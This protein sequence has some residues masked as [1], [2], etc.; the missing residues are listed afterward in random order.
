MHL[1]A[2]FSLLYVNELI[3]YVNTP[4]PL[5]NKMQSIEK[6]KCLIIDDDPLIT[7]LIVH[8]CDKLDEIEYCLACNNAVDGLKLISSQEF[9]VLFLDYNMPE[10]N[11]KAILE[12][13]K[14]NSKV[15]MITSYADFAVDSYNYPQL[16]DYL[17]KPIKFD[18]FVQAINKLKTRQE[19]QASA[20][21]TGSYFIKDGSKWV[22][23]SLADIIYI[24]SDSNYVV[25]TTKKKQVLEL[26]KLKTLEEELPS[27]F[28]RVHRSFIINTDHIEVITR[29][30]ISIGTT[31]IPVGNAY[32]N[33]IDEIITGP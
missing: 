11:G 14:D 3:S 26:K 17:L 16:I 19:D 5:A 9:D 12:L 8:F 2:G 4:N 22:K 23:L 7:D 32:K 6:Y 18:R 13:K 21:S 27:N 15:I 31:M 28:K 25:W 24:K 20:S 33:V 30:N 29:D 1:K 10:L